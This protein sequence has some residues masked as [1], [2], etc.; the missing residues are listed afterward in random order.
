MPQL[1]DPNFH[2][3]IILMLEHDEKGSMG[4]VINKPGPLTLKELGKEQGMAMSIHPERRE[5]PMYIG[6][7]VEPQRGFVLHDA[8]SVEEKLEVMPGLYLSL[9]LDSLRPLLLQP[10]ARLRFCLGYAGWGGKQL[11]GEIARGSWLF[12]EATSEQVLGSDPDTLWDR[13]LR[14]M[15]VD[16]AMLQPGK[17]VH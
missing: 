10:D 8:E 4:I 15:G 13:T 14:G 12:S 17:G 11:E 7:P 9:T 16:P 2:R 5:Q 6:G 1:G 3:A